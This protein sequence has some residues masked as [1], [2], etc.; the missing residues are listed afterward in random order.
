MSSF[1]FRGSGVGVGRTTILSADNHWA[2]R[3][4]S[5][6]VDISSL[7]I[8]SATFTASSR[9]KFY[10]DSLKAWTQRMITNPPT[11]FGF[12]ARTS[13]CKACDV[14]NASKVTVYTSEQAVSPGTYN[15]TIFLRT[16]TP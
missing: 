14:S 3:G 15:P 8:D 12:V 16:T 10:S 2:A 9:A 7:P 13:R 4:C 11:C 5:T 6:G 1:N